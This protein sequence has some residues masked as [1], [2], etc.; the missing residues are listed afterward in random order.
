MPAKGNR[1]VHY[2]S[3]RIRQ[4]SE[5]A[6]I[7]AAEVEFA[8]HG[9]RG[10]AMGSI[11]D[12]AKVPRSN[13]HYYFK[14]KR[15]LYRAV[16]LSIVRRW[17]HIFDQIKPEDDPTDS[18][19]NYIHA[20]VMHAKTDPVSSR[21]FANEMLHGAPVLKD[22]LDGEHREWFEAKTAV[23]RNWVAN[24]KMDPVEPTT[25]ILMIWSSTQQYA[26][27]AVQVNSIYGHPPS[28]QEFEKI[29]DAL[30][31]IILKGCGLT[32]RRKTRAGPGSRTGS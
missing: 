2:R 25:L 19:R 26:D 18:L 28:D 12:R 15:V 27:C 23:I 21:V 8:D 9:F 6:I 29:A 3:G 13:V 17:I 7:R 20:K 16:L 11:A 1:P 31:D 30:C 24:G 5:A 14:N 10:A 4:S 32:T 22:Y